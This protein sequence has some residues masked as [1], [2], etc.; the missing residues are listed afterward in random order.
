ME[1]N[2][3]YDDTSP[4]I[5]KRVIG[6]DLPPLHVSNQSLN[7]IEYIIKNEDYDTAIEISKT[8]EP[9]TSGLLIAQA[10]KW[11][12]NNDYNKFDEHFYLPPSSQCRCSLLPRDR[13]RHIR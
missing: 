5:W 10:N 4:E 13:L 1:V 12:V 11:I 8:I 9:L 6:N 7:N 2:E 3:F